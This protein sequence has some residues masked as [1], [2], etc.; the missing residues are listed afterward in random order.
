MYVK[1]VH[2]VKLHSLK[3]RREGP[4]Y[5]SLGYWQEIGTPVRASGQ[6]LKRK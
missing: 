4:P 5:E 1:I 3:M 2:A 6:R